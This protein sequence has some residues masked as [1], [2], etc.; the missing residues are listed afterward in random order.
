MSQIGSGGFYLPQIYR[1]NQMEV[2]KYFDRGEIDYVDMSQWSFADELLCFALQSGF[3]KFV[4]ETYPNPRKKNEV[5]IWFLIASQLVLRTHNSSKYS[6]LEYF[7]NAGSILTKIGFNISGQGIV[8]FN[9]KNQKQRKTAI[10]HDTVRKYFKDTTAKELRHWYNDDI[11]KWFRIKKTYNSKGIFVLDQSHLV[12][13]KNSNYKDAVYMA[14]DEHGQRYR[15]FDKLT[16]EQKK[17][18]VYHPCYLFSQLLHL[19]ESN[20]NFHIASYELGPGNEDEMVHARK[21][22][23][24]FCEKYPGVMKELILDRGYI[25]GEFIGILKQKYGVDVL[26]PLRSNM[27][28]F[29]DALGIAERKGNWKQTK[30]V[31]KNG[32]IVKE[33]KTHF[34][35]NMDLWEECPLKLQIYVNK[36]R[37]WDDELRDYQEHYWGLAS[38]KKYPSEKAA[39]ERYALRTQVEERFRQLK[40]VWN[41]N[42]FPSPNENLVEAHVGFILLTYSLLQL[43]LKRKELR[44]LNHKTIMTLRQEER[45]GKDVVLAYKNDSFAIFDLDDCLL[46]T[47]SMVLE[48]QQKFKKMLIKQKEVKTKRFS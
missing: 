2:E 41:I 30:C 8:G 37:K 10:D 32:K 44:E 18:I 5:P 1:H 13:P 31:E 46:R 6:Q 45:L 29:K 4:D 42:T 22:V 21:L 43:Y 47:V 23:F 40:K 9:N 15:N 48:N 38:T 35:E 28:D 11:Q 20:E 34:V 27:A 12:V 7:L 33:I 25:N 16:K 24:D 26:I 39:I 3:F 19:D 36:S 14:V 17:A